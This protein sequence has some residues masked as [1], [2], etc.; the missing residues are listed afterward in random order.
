MVGE[1][2]TLDLSDIDLQNIKKYYNNPCES[3]SL[4]F[5]REKIIDMNYGPGSHKCRPTGHVKYSSNVYI[6]KHMCEL[7]LKFIINKMIKRYERS[8]LM[9]NKGWHVHYTNNIN[10]IK[11][12]YENALK[13][14]T[15]LHSTPTAT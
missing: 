13:K 4:C 15:V 2:E 9:R 11:S 3:K 7:G 12:D 14:C 8:E 5:L 1:S 6:N 10:K